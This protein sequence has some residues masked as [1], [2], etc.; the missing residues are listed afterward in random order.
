MDA[1]HQN[2]FVTADENGVV[3]FWDIRQPN[4]IVKAFLA[5]NKPINSVALNPRKTLI[6]TAGGDKAIRVNSDEAH[7]QIGFF[8]VFLGV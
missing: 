5:H 1:K 6:A 4:K 2:L 8:F 3:R 7:T